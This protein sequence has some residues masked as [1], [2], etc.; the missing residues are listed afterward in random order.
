MNYTEAFSEFTVEGS[1]RMAGV[2][3][4]VSSAS[5]YTPGGTWS[6]TNNFQHNRAVAYKAASGVVIPGPTLFTVRSGLV[7][8]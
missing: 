8:R 3:R 5:T 1:Q 7:T 6:G 2:Y 4:I